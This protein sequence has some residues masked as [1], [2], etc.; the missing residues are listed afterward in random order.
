MAPLP[1]FAELA[2]ACG[3]TSLERQLDFYLERSSAADKDLESEIMKVCIKLSE[4][5][6]E[7]Q[8]FLNEVDVLKG[9]VEAVE[10]ANVTTHIFGS[11][12]ILGILLFTFTIHFPKF[13][14]CFIFS[15]DK[16][17]P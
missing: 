6:K 11:L 13:Y 4:S 15:C 8:A 9:R 10:T 1:L 7:A 3:S 14:F 16:S 17:I 5:I 2:N 12:F